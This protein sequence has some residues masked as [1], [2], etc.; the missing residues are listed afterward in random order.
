MSRFLIGATWDD[1]PHLTAQAKQELWDSILPYQRDARAKGIP[2]LGAGAIYPVAESDIRIRDFVIP[3]HWRRGYGMDCGGGSK[4]TA[5]VFGAL[6]PDSH[7]LYITS[8]YKHSASQPS[9]HAAAI[10]DR[11]GLGGPHGWN[12]PGVADAAALIMTEHDSEQLV[13]TYRRL[14]LDL[15]L[16]D[17]SVETG[18]ADVW[19]LMTRGRLRVFGTCVAWFEEFR[20]YQRDKH[21]RIKKVNDHLMDASRYLVRSGIP[22]MKSRPKPVAERNVLEIHH[23]QTP[24]L[25]WMGG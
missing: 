10:K 19:D 1:A 4:P 7:V 6:D 13:F 25:G 16:P 23:G 3:D 21:G 8:V 11:M 22:R 18:I 2:Q 5:A 14:G 17:K 20:M 9:V 24:G 15:E 12:W